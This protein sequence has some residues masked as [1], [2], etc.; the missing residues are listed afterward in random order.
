MFCSKKLFPALCFL[1]ALQ[2]VKSQLP[3]GA[4]TIS[5]LK[6]NKVLKLPWAGGLNA[7]MFSQIDLNND[8]KKDLIAFDKVNNFAFGIFRTF[9]NEGS[10][11]EIKY[12]YTHQY[13]TAFPK[14]QQWAY[15]Y[16]FNNDG[17]SDLFTYVVGG[18]KAFRN[19]SS[20]NSVSFT[21]E[22]N[23]LKSNTTPTAAPT[24]GNIF[25]SAVSL[26]GFSDIDGD[27]DMD[28]LTFSAGGFQLEF[29][30]NLS[31]ELYNH[32]DSLVFQLEE[33]TWGNFS[34]SNCAVVLNQ[35]KTALHSGSCLMCFDRDGDGDKDLLMG[36]IACNQMN[37]L[38]NNG[39]PANANISD[40]TRLYPNYPDK[41]S[42]LPIKLNNF[43]CSYYIDIDND[44]KNDLLVSPNA[45]NTE[46]AKSVWYYKNS[47]STNTVQ[48]EYVKNNFL[49]DEMVEHGEGAWPALADVDADGLLDL[50]VGNRGYYDNG[51]LKTRLA[52]YKNIGTLASPVYSLITEDY[53]GLSVHAATHNL[54]GLVPAF[55]DVDGDGDTDMILG[56]FY[57]KIHWYEN[58]AGSGNAFNFTVFKNHPFNISTPGAPYPQV[59]DVD[60]DNLPDLLIGLR[61]GR[62]AYYRNIGTSTNPSFTLVTNSFGNVNVKG[63]PSLYGTDGSCAPFMYEENGNY[64][65][66]CGSVSGNIYHY[67]QISGNLSGS[68]QLLDSTVNFINNGPNSALQYT[69]INGDGKR[70]L[71]VGNY[72]GGLHF[73]SSK[74]P[75]GLTENITDASEALSLY[76]LPS[77]GY[78]TVKLNS[79][80]K[81]DEY[82][83][84]IQ[85]E[86]GRKV[87]TAV[88]ETAVFSLNC[89]SL[90][91]G[92][93]LLLV[94]QKTKNGHRSY[95]K[96]LIIQK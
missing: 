61:N 54:I 79:N 88:S 46:N 85:D 65:L 76:P 32:A 60:K 27:G 59:I 7:C 81:A 47:S 13:N 42:T 50:I 74:V 89:S 84:E 9:I 22:K 25:S 67:G 41:A 11:G 94:K 96:K 75:I 16:D 45:I 5:V 77:S 29:H 53:A 10:T 68:F 20:G 69:D 21:L 43:P 34:E 8:G 92:V 70:D 17:K 83:V 49:Q 40:T 6:N 28:I 24:P 19:T 57:G 23:F 52:F 38:Q 91:N 87:L 37:Y 33:S 95:T 90:N 51:T 63:P 64:K 80:I 35:F 55:G 2:Q 39:T 15:F 36:D 78:I 30:K 1:L 58:T 31:K 18:I 44:S 71:I 26:P 3:V 82:H 56:D 48:F 72:A 73:Y 62:L 86:L 66:L 4:D 93:Y 12:R 14:V